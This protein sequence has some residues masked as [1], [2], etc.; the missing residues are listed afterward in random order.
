MFYQAMMNLTVHKTAIILLLHMWHPFPMNNYVSIMPTKRRLYTQKSALILAS[1]QRKLHIH[2]GSPY[3]YIR[4]SRA[5]T[6]SLDCSGFLNVF[7]CQS[8][9]RSV[10]LCKWLCVRVTTQWTNMDT[11]V[12]NKF[13]EQRALLL[14]WFPF[15]CAVL[16][17]MLE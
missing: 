5:F 12:L 4:M 6:A 8:S 11:S 9:R 16:M 17:D 2:H 10:F 3:Q 14:I 1:R 15:N 13:W 7:V